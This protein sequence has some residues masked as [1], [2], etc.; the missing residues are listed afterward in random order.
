MLASYS[1]LLSYIIYTCKIPHRTGFN[2]QVVAPQQCEEFKQSN[3]TDREIPCP[4][5]NDECTWFRIKNGSQV[6]VE[7]RF[8]NLSNNNI[9]LQRNDRSR[10]GYGLFNVTTSQSDSFCYKVCPVE[11]GKCIAIYTSVVLVNQN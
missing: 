4:D 8:L 6:S 5:V 1:S 3:Y 9:E 7:S 11:S 10:Y 2:I